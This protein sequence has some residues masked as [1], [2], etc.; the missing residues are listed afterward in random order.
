MLSLVLPVVG[1]G[2]ALTLSNNHAFI[3]G[4]TLAP[5]IMLVISI[6]VVVSGAT[7]LQLGYTL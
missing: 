1:A 2:F 6:A 7:A 3:T 5:N 4:T